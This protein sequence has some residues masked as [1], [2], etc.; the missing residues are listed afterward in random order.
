MKLG[1]GALP[2]NTLAYDG[3][4]GATDEGGMGGGWGA[5]KFS[6]NEVGF[7]VAGFLAS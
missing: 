1:M 7:D 4:W 5:I 3:G 2:F 6:P